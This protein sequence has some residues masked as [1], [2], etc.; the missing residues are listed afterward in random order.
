MRL[1]IAIA[2]L[3]SAPGVGV[4]VLRHGGSVLATGAIAVPIA[5][6]VLLGIFFDQVLLRRAPAI[7]TFEHELTHAVCALLFLRRIDRF[8]VRRNG[9]GAVQHHG[10]FG[11]T[12]GDDFIG[13][14]PYFLPTFTVVMI[15]VRPLLGPR[16]FPGFDV[17]IGGTLGFH[18]WTTARE[19]RENWTGTTFADAVSGR[20]TRTDIA[21]RGFVYS[22]L[23]IAVL[24]LAVTGIL[25]AILSDGYAGFPAWA[26]SVWETT[27][28]FW[29]W[30][31]RAARSHA[32]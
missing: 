26:R 1:L 7:E 22:L 15:L 13:L 28:R 6:G 31:L 21:E 16:W 29:S 4:A 24:G 19:T 18:L 27:L 17:G 8:V 2:L 10:R 20:E 23:F 9:A 25:A 5:A 30:G 32:S 11:G 14:A 3:A 12:I